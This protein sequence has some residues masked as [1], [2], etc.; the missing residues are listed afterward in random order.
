MLGEVSERRRKKKECLCLVFVSVRERKRDGNLSAKTKIFVGLYTLDL[1]CDIQARQVYNVSWSD[2][3]N[4]NLP[5]MSGGDL[6][7]NHFE[8]AHA[9]RASA[10][11]PGARSSGEEGEGTWG[12][13]GATGA[14]AGRTEKTEFLTIRQ[15]EY[16]L[17]FAIHCLICLQL[18]VDYYYARF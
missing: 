15:V 10:E 2:L 16:H 5:G 3:R 9:D 13:S 17:C 8:F 4:K 11:R 12:A 18:V 1:L 14:R 6:G 7:T